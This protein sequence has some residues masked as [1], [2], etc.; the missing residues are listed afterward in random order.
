MTAEAEASELVR[1]AAL[2]DHHR[3]ILVARVGGRGTI[4]LRVIGAMTVTVI[5][6]SL[7]TVSAG[8]G[9]A[10]RG[11]ILFLALRAVVERKDSQSALA[12]AQYR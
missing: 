8:G 3:P 1:R 11:M 10:M 12:V 5:S 7:R 4:F 6:S 2:R 9:G